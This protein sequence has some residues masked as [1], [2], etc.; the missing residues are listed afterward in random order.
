MYTLHMIHFKL[1]K[2]IKQISTITITKTLHVI[3]FK[4]SQLHVFVRPSSS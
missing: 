4:N 1:F 2:S 3:H